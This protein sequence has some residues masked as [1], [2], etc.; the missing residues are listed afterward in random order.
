[1]GLDPGSVSASILL[2]KQTATTTTTTTTRLTADVDG[3]SQIWVRDLT[4]LLYSIWSLRRNSLC[5]SMDS[6]TTGIFVI[7]FGRM[8]D[9]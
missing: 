2:V 8:G 6:L 7:F 9:I 3:R 5:P 1:V 4:D